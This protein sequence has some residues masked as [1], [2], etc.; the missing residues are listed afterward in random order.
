MFLRWVKGYFNSR[1]RPCRLVSNRL[2][3]R[4]GRLP[5]DQIK[6]SILWSPSYLGVSSFRASGHF[7]SPLRNLAPRSF[8]HSA[9]LWPNGRDICGKIPSFD[10]ID[11]PGV[12]LVNRD[13]KAEMTAPGAVG[14]SRGQYSIVRRASDRNV[15]TRLETLVRFQPKPSPSFIGS[16]LLH[17]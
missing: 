8:S 13:Q 7:D 17:R 12:I 4:K 10:R 6:E 3:R 14:F 1:H 5:T 15:W 16:K 11:L 2:K 9:E